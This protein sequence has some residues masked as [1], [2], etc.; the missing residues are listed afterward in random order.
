MGQQF[1]VLQSHQQPSGAAWHSMLLS[2]HIMAVQSSVAL[3]CC[4]ILPGIQ[5]LLMLAGNAGL[6]FVLATTIRYQ[7]M[8]CEKPPVLP[9]GVRLPSCSC[10]LLL[11]CAHANSKRCS[12]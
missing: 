10:R 6:L 12:C 7:G 8:A 2:S 5:Q 4:S 3:L 11:R 9:M 1:A